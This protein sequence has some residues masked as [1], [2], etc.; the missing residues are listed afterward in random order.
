MDYK[1][2]KVPFKDRLLFL[3]TGIIN[4][5]YLNIQKINSFS[6][7]TENRSIINN[8]K[9]VDIEAETKV[10]IPFFEFDVN[11]TKSNL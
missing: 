8:I 4:E 3:F 2:I 6:L 7:P 9:E 1:K 11:K 10:D 5:K